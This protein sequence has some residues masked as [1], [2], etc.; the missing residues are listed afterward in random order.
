MK[1]PLN[2]D[3]EKKKHLKVI[4][5]IAFQKIQTRIQTIELSHK[6][7]VFRLN[8]IVFKFSNKILKER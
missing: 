4:L 6:Y 5:I 7:L 1:R 8:R 3:F 2:Y